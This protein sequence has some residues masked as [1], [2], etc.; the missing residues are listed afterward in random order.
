MTPDRIVRAL[1]IPAWIVI[2]HFYPFEAIAAL[3]AIIV[4]QLTLMR[5]KP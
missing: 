4:N 3:L 1:A 5:G 2:A